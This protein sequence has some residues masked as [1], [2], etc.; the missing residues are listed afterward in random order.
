V[1][2]QARD[3]QSVQRLGA[4]LGDENTE[5]RKE[6]WWAITLIGTREA[7]DEARRFISKQPLPNPE[8]Y[9]Y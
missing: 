7:A 1:V 3:A 9:R 8:T 4:L 5:V 2:G 6:A